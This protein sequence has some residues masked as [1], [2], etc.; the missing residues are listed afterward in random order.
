[1]CE[2]PLLGGENKPFATTVMPPPKVASAIPPPRQHKSLQRA[3]TVGHVHTYL[4]ALN[5]DY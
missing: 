3:G 2:A 1:M 4:G 5:L